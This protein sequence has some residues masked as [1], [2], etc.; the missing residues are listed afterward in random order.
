MHY[1]FINLP[2]EK[3]LDATTAIMMRTVV[4]PFIFSMNQKG[5]IFKRKQEDLKIL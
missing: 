3:A 5:I 1:Q 4:R 2:I